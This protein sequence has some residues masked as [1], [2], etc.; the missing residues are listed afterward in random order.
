LSCTT[1][2]LLGLSKATNDYVA[3]LIDKDV[4]RLEVTMDDTR[5]MQALNTLNDFCGVEAGALIA[6][7]APAV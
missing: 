6:K 3:T 5:C 4:F 7:T 2:E 1:P